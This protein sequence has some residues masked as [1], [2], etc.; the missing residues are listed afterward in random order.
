MNDE[1]FPEAGKVEMTIFHEYGQVI[2]RFRRP[3]LFVAYDPPNAKAVA[4]ALTDA[5]FEAAH[6]PKPAGESVKSALIERHHDVLVPRI[7]LM[8]QGL[9]EDKK[10][11]DG[12]VAEQ[13]VST[14]FHE[15]FA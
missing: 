12:Y 8:L 1:A 14:I 7:A 3:M 2:Q 13:L 9:R 6:E 10:L 15:I 5:A 4:C 11:S